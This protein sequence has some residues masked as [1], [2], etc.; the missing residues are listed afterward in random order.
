MVI[1]QREM[2]AL[3]DVELASELFRVSQ[4]QCRPLR[5]PRTQVEGLEEIQDGARE[6]EGDQ[7]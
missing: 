5:R 4:S 7:V 1:V 2:T 6:T 3:S